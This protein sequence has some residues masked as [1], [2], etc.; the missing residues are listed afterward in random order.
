MQLLLPSSLTQAQQ[1][2]SWLYKAESKEGSDVTAACSDDEADSRCQTP[3][4]TS[5]EGDTVHEPAASTE[6]KTAMQEIKRSATAL[7]E[8]CK[9]QL[10]W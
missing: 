7:V 10:S 3:S 2:S 5:T 8:A 4:D 6:Q 9:Q 1:R